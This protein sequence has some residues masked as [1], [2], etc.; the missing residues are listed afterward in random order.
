MLSEGT[1]F[2]MSNRCSNIVGRGGSGRFPLV[3]R[4][5]IVARAEQLLDD[6]S[7]GIVL[8]GEGGIGKSHIA[9]EVLRLGA[10][11]GFATASTVGTQAA[12]GIPLGALSH[13]LPD[14]AGPSGNVLAAARTA[15]AERAG[16]RP[17]LLSVDDAHLLDN[18]S[19]ALILQLAMSMRSFVVA[20]IRVGEPIPDPV[21]AL[22]KEGLAERVEVGPLDDGS[23]EAITALVL[24]GPIERQVSGAVVNRADGNP[25]VARELCLA[26][27]ESGAIARHDGAWSLAGELAPTARIAELVEARVEG[28]DAVERRALDVVALAEPLS[29]RVAQ[30]LG[31]PDALIGLERRGLV[32]MREDGKRREL[33]L[34]HPFYADVVRASAGPLLAASIKAELADAMQAT[35]MRRRVD[36]IRVAT[37]QLE[38]G[39]GDSQLLLNA[40]QETYRAR[41]MA[42]TARLAAGAWDIQPDAITGYLLG[43]AIGFMGRHGEADAILSAATELATND[44]DYARLVLAN[45][46]VLSA[47]LGM[48]EAA[49]ALLAAADEQVSGED[50]RVTLRA[51][52]AHLL[53]F[54]GDVDQAIDLV[55]PILA[56]GRG[57][58]VVVAAMAALIAYGLN[59]RYAAAIELA[60]RVLPEHVRLWADGLVLIPPELV[61][62]QADGAR[63]AMGR[64]GTFAVPEAPLP[65]RTPT[66]NRPIAMLRALHAALAAF[67]RGKPRQA[68]A[69][70]DQVGPLPSDPLASSAEG[71]MALSAALTGRADTATRALARAEESMLRENRSSNPMMD[72]ARIWTLVVLGRPHDARR[73][74]L[75]AIDHALEAHRWGVGLDLAHD[76]ARI[77]GPGEAMAVLE[78]IGDRVDG[79]L[80]AA[81]RQHIEG[82]GRGDADRLEMA[83][84][85]FAD[86]G[87]GL[88]AAEA[89]ADAGRAARRNGEAR[90]STRLLQRAASLARSTEDAQTPALVMPDELTP[91]T[92]R[93]REIA[94][95]AASGLS[96]DAIARQL[97]VSVR[98]VDNHMQHV[99][100][101]L[102]IGSR[103]ELSAAMK[104]RS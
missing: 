84:A 14:L 99:Y 56:D 98:T 45:S 67:L 70:I 8:V 64:L 18:H 69:I 55:E 17:L 31:S 78:R 91:L 29:L 25:L 16:D 96:S 44:E 97:F 38:A 35:G 88:F 13:L 26:G 74:A 15:L 11:R 48:P 58:A 54:H 86:L 82:L 72:H 51:Q 71:L 62:I 21:V 60:E 73:A 6:G 103:A 83:S 1:Q 66:A 85:A 75:D 27:L 104:P 93:E 80:A 101:K 42:G 36:L 41:D 40:A 57:P 53:A 37:W 2:R 39:R 79:P 95:L 90:R 12:A 49:I 77:G 32:V 100:Q 87:A 81:R 28:L 22:W 52:R 7:G 20:T 59:G 92:A 47:G 68:Q 63:V 3:G 65:S 34:S 46:S 5:Q 89:A 43:T 19:A 24:D 10:E 102:G 50:A 4:E 33:W 76:L 9:S 23:I 94:S 30:E 61:Q